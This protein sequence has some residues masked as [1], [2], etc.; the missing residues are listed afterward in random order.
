MI[1]DHLD[2][3]RPLVIH[4]ARNYVMSRISKQDL[5]INTVGVQKTLNSL[6]SKGIISEG[7]TLTRGDILEN[8]NRKEIYNFIANNPG[9]YSSQIVRE[10]DISR[11]S[12]DWHISKLVE[13]NF[14]RK[15]RINNFAVYATI[16]TPQKIVKLNHFV[17]KHKSRQIL[18]LLTK[19]NTGLSIYKISKELEIHHTTVG[20][21]IHRFLELDIV[22]ETKDSSASC[23][24]SLTGATSNLIR[25]R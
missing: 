24:Y 23:I 1:R 10:L 13:F 12:V 16:E 21:Y 11:Y 18:E 14:I 20:K 17:T 6:I 25:K 4:D 8:E 9:V 2:D 5:N 3:N 15:Y 19:K 22:K 7:S